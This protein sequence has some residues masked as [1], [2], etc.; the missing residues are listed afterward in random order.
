[1]A[2]FTRAHLHRQIVKKNLELLKAVNGPAFFC[3][4]IKANAYGHGLEQVAPLVAE[5]GADCAGVALVEE[6]VELRRLGFKLPILTF[7]PLVAGDIPG[8]NEYQLTP[9]IGRFEDLAVLPKTP[10]A[11]H[12]KFNTGMQRLGFDGEQLSELREKL[13]SAGHLKIE[14]VCTHFTHGEDIQDAGGPTAQQFEKFFEMVAGFPGVR[15]AHKSSTLAASGLSKVHPEVGARP[16]ISIYGLPHDGNRVGAG[17][18]PALSWHTQLINVHQVE[19]G[20]TV[21]YSGRWTAARRS[22]IGVVPLG[23]GDGYSRSL[24]NKGQM[25]FRGQ[26]VPVT[27]SVCMDYVLLDLTD[28]CKEGAAKAGEDVVV[29]GRQGGNQ[30][31]A[32][33]VAE[34]AGTISYEVVTAISARVKR[35]AV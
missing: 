28:A 23:Y 24:S 18:E 27:G 26:K 22:T 9:V 13:K 4:M 32:W 6:G 35:E 2:R 11:V 10:R 14:G 20:A 33:D 3:P 31:T 19:Q 1:M 30:I 7:A 5:S 15:H 17:L 16:G 34:R 21:S 25:L 12:L 8:L 29:I